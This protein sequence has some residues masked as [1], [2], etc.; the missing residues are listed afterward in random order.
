MEFD[1]E[2][3][4]EIFGNYDE[5]EEGIE[6]KYSSSQEDAYIL[7]S[8]LDEKSSKSVLNILLGFRD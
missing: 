4:I 5:V 3:E 2:E 8:P 1:S 6:S 7:E